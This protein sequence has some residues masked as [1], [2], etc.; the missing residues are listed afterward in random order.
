MKKE[1]EAASQEIRSAI[2]K[3]VEESLQRLG[4]ARTDDLQI[5]TIRF[6]ALEKRLAAK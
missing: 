6:E 5:L 3:R 4:V 2:D 1:G